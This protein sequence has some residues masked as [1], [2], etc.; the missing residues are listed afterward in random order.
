MSDMTANEVVEAP[1][2]EPPQPGRTHSVLYRIAAGNALSGVLAVVLAFLVG[3][4]MIAATISGLPGRRLEV[5]PINA[6]P[7]TQRTT[8]KTP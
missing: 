1:A 7:I 2:P 3:S 8:I 5:D 4:V 6:L